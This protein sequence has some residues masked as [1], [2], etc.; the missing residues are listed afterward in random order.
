MILATGTK[1]VSVNVLAYSHPAKSA[2]VK[3]G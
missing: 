3:L 1:S 2:Q